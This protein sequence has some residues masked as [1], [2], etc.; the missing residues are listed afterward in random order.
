MLTAR[1]IVKRVGCLDRQTELAGMVCGARLCDAVD[2]FL[3]AFN[4]VQCGI[5]IGGEAWVTASSVLGAGYPHVSE[6]HDMELLVY[7]RVADGRCTFLDCSIR[8]YP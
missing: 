3:D 7:S 2:L 6:F 4:F 5:D 8:C 1:L